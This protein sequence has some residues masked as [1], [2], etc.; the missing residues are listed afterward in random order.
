M[1]IDCHTHI[2]GYKGSPDD[3]P[4]LKLRR[5]GRTGY[6]LEFADRLGIDKICLSLGTSRDYYPTPEVIAESN[7]MVWAEAERY[8]DR[9]IGFCYLNPRYLQ[10]SL[11]EMDR[12]IA[13]GPFRGI[14]LW[15]AIHVDHPNLDPIADKAAELGVPILQHTWI[16][17]AGNLPDESEPRHVAAIAERHPQ[18]TFI[19]AHSGGNWER[20]YKTI[21]EHQNVYGEL[22]GGDPEMGQAEMAVR[23]LGA[24]RLVWGSDA[25]GRS[26]A[27]QLSKVTGADLTEDEKAAI[28]GGNMERILG[29]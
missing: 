1:V 28:L 11:A 9:I 22:A 23:L 15:V 4:S 17:I 14:K 10:E 12:C 20:G 3:P 16:K 25:P 29:L 19:M 7:D 27:S 5:T 24:D 6:L 26:F 18:T 13:N 21:I 2:Q 8:P